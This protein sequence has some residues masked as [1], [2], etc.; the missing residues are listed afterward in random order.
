MH[1]D[2]GATP[3]PN[4]VTSVRT[5]TPSAPT[6]CA[7]P[8]TP[9][10]PPTSRRAPSGPAPPRVPDHPERRITPSGGGRRPRRPPP[11]TVV[12]HPRQAIERSGHPRQATERSGHPRQTIITVANST[13]APAVIRA[14]N[15]ANSRQ[16]SRVSLASP[17]VATGYS[18]I[19]ECRTPDRP[20]DRPTVSGRESTTA[21]YGRGTG[22]VDEHRPRRRPV[23][24]G[25]GRLLGR[26]RRVAGIRVA[27]PLEAVVAGRGPVERSRGRERVHADTA[28]SEIR[29]SA[30]VGPAG[31][32]WTETYGC[33]TCCEGPQERRVP[34][35]R[36][37]YR[38]S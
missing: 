21:G 3:P 32:S 6:G 9:A 36:S 31:V 1:I 30:G 16:L 33:R 13:S 34:F 35:F 28:E 22:P 20:A 8:T 17:R 7:F 11:A 15:A 10:V 12:N 37:A 19:D 24:V 26:P 14:A 18:S 29:R 5:S 38:V 2:L 4:G 23:R 25:C 27:V